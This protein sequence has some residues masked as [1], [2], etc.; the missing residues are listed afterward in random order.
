MRNLLILVIISTCSF[1]QTNIVE[2]FNTFYVENSNLIDTVYNKEYEQFCKSE[3]IDIY[4]DHNESIFNKLYF[5]HQAFTVSSPING[6]NDGLLGIPY[7]DMESRVEYV[8]NATGVDRTPATF[9]SDL[10]DSLGIYYDRHNDKPVFTFGWC[11]EREMAF[12][13]LLRNMGFEG[14]IVAAGGHAWSE[15]QIEFYSDGKLTDYVLHIDNT[16]ER[17]DIVN[18]DWVQKPRYLHDCREYDYNCEVCLMTDFYNPRSYDRIDTIMVSEFVEEDI[19][20]LLQLKLCKLF[21]S[22]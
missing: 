14:T 22:L 10:V 5:M 20:I 11:A 15:I 3:Q 16:F 2:F 21:K 8:D 19:T 4:N 1:A 9:L 18:V 12:M 13:A 17:F 7:Y 6:L